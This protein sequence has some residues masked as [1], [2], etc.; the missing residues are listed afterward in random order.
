VLQA[1][2]LTYGTVMGA[3]EMLRLILE[4]APTTNRVCALNQ[5]P[6]PDHSVWLDA[7]HSMVFPG[8]YEKGRAELWTALGCAG[9]PG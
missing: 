9:T 4:R 5:V 2:G 1:I 3:R 8:P 6:L 7:C